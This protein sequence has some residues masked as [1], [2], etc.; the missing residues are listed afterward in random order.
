M[1]KVML[2]T[3]A[4]ILSASIYAQEKAT[5]KP[6]ATVKKPERKTWKKPLYGG[7]TAGYGSAGVK[8]VPGDNQFKPATKFGLTFITERSRIWAW[9]AGL[10]LSAEG[11]KT[12]V[13]G[14]E[15]SVTPVYLRMPVRGY[16]FF[17]HGCAIRPMAYFGPEI[18]VKVAESSSGRVLGSESSSG[19]TNAK[20]FR[21]FD[22]GI[23]AGVGV[24]I[25]AV[26]G[27]WINLDGGLYKGF[28]DA[29]EH[30]GGSFN[31]HKNFM[32]SLSVLFALKK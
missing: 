32:G 21:S 6:K 27:I 28:S 31:E 29:L 17:T 20:Q 12:R 11:Y 13:Q 26:D 1:K 30:S 2:F 10:N 14:G 23:N 18:G 16:Y 24:N 15:S 3:I 25:R 22:A 19:N 4:T 8:D 7:I 5:E 9:G